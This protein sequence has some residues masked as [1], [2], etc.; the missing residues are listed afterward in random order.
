ME[1]KESFW[2]LVN[3]YK[4]NILPEETIPSVIRIIFTKYCA[5]NY[6]LSDT[7]EE[8]MIYANIHKSI[9]NRDVDGFLESA[10]AAFE[11]IDS[12]L[13]A[14]GLILRAQYALRN[15]F[16]GLTNKKKSYSPENNRAL[17][18]AISEIDLSNDNISNEDLFKELEE[19]IY[20]M[21]AS[22]GRYSAGYY[23]SKSINTLVKEL[24]RVEETDTY[25]DFACGCGLSDITIAE[26]KG[27]KHYYSDINEELV[28]LAIM[29]N[30]IRGFQ[31]EKMSFKVNDILIN[32]SENAGATKIFVDF[33]FGIRVNKA[34]T[35][36]SDGSV[37]AIHRIIE[38][39]ANGG[40]AI[41]TCPTALFSKTDKESSSLRHTLLENKLIK[42]IIALPPV[43]LGTLVNVNLLLLSKEENDKVLFVDASRNDIVQFSNNSRKANAELTPSGIE[44]I[45]NIFW[46]RLE[47]KGVS[48]LIPVQNLIKEDSL[49]PKNYIEIEEKT[50]MPSY[51]EINKRLNTLYGSLIKSLKDM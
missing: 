18:T 47:V 30:I 1:I 24:L 6:L 17:L 5:D 23:S 35:G 19:F 37:L 8:M 49:L 50:V 12:K 16:L 46:K 40:Q 2:N 34:E 31:V 13:R 39:L 7:R 45:S 33:P 26:G 9:A 3:L 42:S 38:S 11:Y 43:T 10:S 29:L 48:S 41:I 22:S 28:Q 27:T 25:L 51:S 44:D 21:A 14:N 15:D 20:I 32:R 36:Y 4:S